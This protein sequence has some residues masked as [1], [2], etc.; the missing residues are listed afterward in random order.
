MKNET[1]FQKAEMNTNSALTKD[2][3]NEQPPSPGQNKTN[4]TPLVPAKAPDPANFK[5][6]TGALHFLL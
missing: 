3:D 4:F 1:N 6:C 2:N 5:F